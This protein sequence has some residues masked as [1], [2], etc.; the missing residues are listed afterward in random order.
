MLDQL[1]AHGETLVAE[2]IGLACPV[3][4]FEVALPWRSSVGDVADS[5]KLRRKVGLL[6][7]HECARRFELAIQS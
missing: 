1:L 6:L 5:N 2:G 7:V 3:L 4:T